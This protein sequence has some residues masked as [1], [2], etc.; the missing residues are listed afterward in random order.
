[1]QK[2]CGSLS[3][4][5][6]KFKKLNCFVHPFI[7]NIWLRLACDL[8]GTKTKVGVGVGIE[9]WFMQLRLAGSAGVPRA[10][11]IGIA[12]KMRS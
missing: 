11:R 2:F 8:T 9:S 6:M 3:L 7:G 10:Q 4:K 5:A 1:M 12:M